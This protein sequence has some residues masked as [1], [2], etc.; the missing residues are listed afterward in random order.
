MEISKTKII[1]QQ[2]LAVPKPYGIIWDMDNTL[3][4]THIDFRLMHKRVCS[5]LA[6]KNLL[7]PDYAQKTTAEVLMEMKSFPYYDA[8]YGAAAWSIVRDVEK[9]GMEEAKLE[10]GVLEVLAALSQ[11]A[12][13]VVLTNNSQVP[14]EMGLIENGVIEL[15]DGIYGRESVPDLKPSSAGVLQILGI[16]SHVPRENWLLVGDAGID[17]RAA[18]GAGIAFGSYTGSRQEDLAI[19]RPVV[20]FCAWQPD[21]AREIINFLGYRLGK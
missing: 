4:R 1:T 16:F 19:Y 17:A 13:M 5:Y 2:K 8:D 7:V 18:I 20:Q 10:P 11:E 12:H 9:M 21:C 14:A 3:L 6:E 15:F